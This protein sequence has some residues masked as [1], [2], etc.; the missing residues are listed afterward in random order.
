[1]LFCLPLGRVRFSS[2]EGIIVTLV[3]L[4]LSFFVVQR[5]EELRK[6]LIG[7]DKCSLVPSPA[8]QVQSRLAFVCFS[9]PHRYRVFS[10]PTRC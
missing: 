5:A 9:D 4:G 8:G 10:P 1:M 6:S 3:D 7:D 2:E